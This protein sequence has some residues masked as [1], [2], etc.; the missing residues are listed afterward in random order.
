MVDKNLRPGRLVFREHWSSSLPKFVKSKR[1]MVIG[2]KFGNPMALPC[3]APKKL[4]SSR[5]IWW[6]VKMDRPLVAIYYWVSNKYVDPCYH[7]FTTE[8][9]LLSLKST[10]STYSKCVIMFTEFDKSFSEWS[11]YSTAQITKIAFGKTILLI[12][13]FLNWS[14]DIKKCP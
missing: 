2:Q 12:N 11:K 7:H 14:F 6:T 3:S 4:Q 13:Y 5:L 8:V 9:M 1:S 10:K